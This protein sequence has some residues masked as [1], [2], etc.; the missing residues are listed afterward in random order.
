[1]TLGQWLATWVAHDFT[2]L[3]QISRVL[4]GQYR[5]AA[6]PWQAYLRVLQS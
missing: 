3:A 1:M 6:G 2:H 4:A 5:E